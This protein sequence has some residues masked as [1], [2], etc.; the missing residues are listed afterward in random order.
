[1][2]G[3]GKGKTFQISPFSGER[4]GWVEILGITLGEH[5]IERFK[6]FDENDNFAEF[7]LLIFFFRLRTCALTCRGRNKRCCRCRPR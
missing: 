4:P 6:I 5:Q 2:F 7:F 1:M 3:Q